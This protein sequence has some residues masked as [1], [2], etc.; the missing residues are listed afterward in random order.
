M[1]A[2]GRSMSGLFFTLKMLGMHIEKEP[3]QNTYIQ[4]LQHNK[5]YFKYTTVIRMPGKYRPG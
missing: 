1:I 5:Y 4:H 2:K 3:N